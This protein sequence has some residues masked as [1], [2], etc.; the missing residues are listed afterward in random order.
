MEDDEL[1]VLTTAV[2]GSS[3][4]FL[5]LEAGICRGSSARFLAAEEFG[6]KS[7][8]YED[9]QQPNRTVSSVTSADR[10]ILSSDVWIR[11]KLSSLRGMH[12]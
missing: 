5:F 11:L 7:L 1:W 3:V 4:P 6:R 12:W 2:C 10:P 8:V 9:L